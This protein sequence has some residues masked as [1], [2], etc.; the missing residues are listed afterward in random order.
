M[1][2]RPG[3]I[4]ESAQRA[5][6]RPQRLTTTATLKEL[7][8]MAKTN[9]SSKPLTPEARLQ[10]GPAM[11]DVNLNNGLA[12][13]SEREKIRRLALS[14]LTKSSDELVSRLGSKKAAR[15]VFCFLVEDLNEYIAWRKVDLELIEKARNRLS[16][17]LGEGALDRISRRA[18]VSLGAGHA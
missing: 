1:I 13:D 16:L 17:V 7:T 2:Y 4:R 18:R 9:R 8:I 14:V 11:T 10:F 6:H 15:V 5:S 3:G 12:Q